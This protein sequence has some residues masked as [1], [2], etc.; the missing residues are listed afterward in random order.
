VP[1]DQAR[2]LHQLHS[3][4]ATLGLFLAIA[5]ILEPGPMTDA[6]FKDWGWRIP[7]LISL[8]L[9]IIALYIRLQMKESPISRNQIHRYD[10]RD[11]F[12]EA[13]TVPEIQTVPDS[14]FGATAVR[15]WC[16]TP[17]SLRS[18]LYDDDPESATRDAQILVAKAL[19]LGMPFF[20]C[21]VAL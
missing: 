20:V 1:D 13:F 12:E 21:L 8:L 19:L 4:S 11:S 16:G 5:V 18:V 7:F 9:V 10:F 3:D 14:L 17:V 15:E 6:A 2:F